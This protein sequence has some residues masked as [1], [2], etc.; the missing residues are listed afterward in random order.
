M[1]EAARNIKEIAGPGGDVEQYRAFGCVDPGLG[2]VA[3]RRFERRFGAIGVDAPAL[4]A[5]ALE[6]EHLVRVIMG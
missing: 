6:R 1:E 4:F 2:I 5:G 3:L